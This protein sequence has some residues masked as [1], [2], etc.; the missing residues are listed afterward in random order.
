MTTINAINAPALLTD[1]QLLIG[2]TSTGLPSASTITAGTGITVVNAGGTITLNA[3]GGGASTI[4][5]TGTSAS[6]VSNTNYIANNAGLVTLTMPAT[7]ALGGIIRVYGK[8]AGG[9]LVQLNGGQTINLG[10]NPTTSGGSLAST[11]QFDVVEISCITA[12]T[13]FVCNGVQ[14]FL[15]PA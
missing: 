14:G 10:S 9:W 2:N 4:E 11:N 15:T 3:V 6:M 1:G 12:N 7:V 5:V 13:T 8:G